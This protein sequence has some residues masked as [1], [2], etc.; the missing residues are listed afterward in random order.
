MATVAGY[1]CTSYDSNDWDSGTSATSD[2]IWCQWTSGTSST[3]GDSSVLGGLYGGLGGALSGGTAQAP[4]RAQ[5]QMRQAAMA[6]HA[7]RQMAQMIQRSQEQCTYNNRQL[8]NGWIKDSL[9]D[10]I[11]LLYERNQAKINQI[12]QQI[13]ADELREEKEK[14]ERT[15]RSMLL[16]IIGEDQYKI[17]EETGNLLVKGRRNDYLISNRG[18]VKRVT[19][20]K[21]IDLCVHLQER[22]KY[23]E[24]DNIITLAMNFKHNE[25]RTDRAANDYHSVPKGQLPK[26]ANF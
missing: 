17:Y 10:K 16:D 24:T 19:K 3:T 22:Y 18:N 8:Y 13:I 21:I 9:T 4:G 6:R 11:L 7:D 12:W 2:N 23:P 26:A 14:A 5:Q 15:A 25:W 1:S 20:D